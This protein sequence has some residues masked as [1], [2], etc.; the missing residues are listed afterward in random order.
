MN[1]W[2]LDLDFEADIPSMI[3]V[4]IH[5]QHLTLHYWND[6]SLKAIGNALGKYIDKFETKEGII[7]YARIC[8]KLDLEKGF[9]K[10][11]KLSLKNW[12]QLQNLNYK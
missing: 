12:N 1:K 8:I 9:P 5:L 3:P 7:S 11:I 6:Q 10:V 4:Q 2:T